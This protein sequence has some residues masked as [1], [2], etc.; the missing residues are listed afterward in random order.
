VTLWQQL[1]FQAPYSGNFFLS[2]V[3]YIEQCR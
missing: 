1:L 2:K 3:W